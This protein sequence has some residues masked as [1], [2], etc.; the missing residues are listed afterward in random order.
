MTNITIERARGDDRDR[1]AALLATNDLPHEDVG[2]NAGRFFIATTGSET[3]GAGGI[4]RYGS[5]GLLRSVVITEPNRGKGYG[6]G[7]CDALEERART[8]G[9]ER[10]YLLTT[11]ASTFFEHRGY[12]KIGREIVPPDIKQTTEF[13]ALCPSSATCMTKDIP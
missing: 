3:V 11:T 12:E 1:V 8:S 4:E 6:V 10:L 9:I 13:T 5:N 2:T 7:L